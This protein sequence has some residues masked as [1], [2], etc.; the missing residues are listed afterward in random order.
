M[1]IEQV[2]GKP[3]F[4]QLKGIMLSGMYR[5]P[6]EAQNVQRVVD[7]IQSN[8]IFQDIFAS[9]DGYIV[10][11]KSVATKNPISADITHFFKNTLSITFKIKQGF[12]SKLFSAGRPPILFN[13]INVEDSKCDFYGKQFN[14]DIEDNFNFAIRN[15]NED[16]FGNYVM[17]KRTLS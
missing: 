13:L 12:L 2:N 5:N 14:G 7:S 3:S 16:D 11:D 4:K 9:K 8:R 10:L 6:S 15:Y 1:Q 17:N